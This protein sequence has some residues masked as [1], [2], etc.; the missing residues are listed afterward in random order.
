MRKHY[1][2][3]SRYRSDFEREHAM[4]K[5]KEQYRIRRNYIVKEFNNIGLTCHLPRGSF[6][7]FPSISST[8]LSS[9]E[10]AVRLLKEERVAAIPVMPLVRVEKVLFVV[11]L[12][13]PLKKLK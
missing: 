11:V 4:L 7:T 13:L 5:M 10:F 1:K 12:R 9:K 6:Y 8:G 2:P 3:G